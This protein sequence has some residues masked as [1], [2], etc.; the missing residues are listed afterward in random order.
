MQDDVLLVQHTG[1]AE[2]DAASLVD[3]A[4]VLCLALE[5]TCRIVAPD[6]SASRIARGEMLLIRSVSPRSGPRLVRAARE[7]DATILVVGLTP[8]LLDASL[9]RPVTRATDEPALARLVEMVRA[10]LERSPLRD[11]HAVKHLM[12]SML[13]C[14]LRGAEREAGTARDPRIA[15][16]LERMRA[17]P[18]HAFTVRALAKHAGLSRAAFARRFLAET[19]TSPQRHLT[20]LRLAR[21]ASLLVEADETL[22]AIAARVGYAN[23]FAFSRAFK[24][25]YGEA[26]QTYRRRLTSGAIRPTARTTF[27]MRMAA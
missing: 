16:V 4:L 15:R 1:V 14:V 12:A 11:A 13:L 6:G 7:G 2:L 3:R 22:A 21:A 19:G 23:E 18:H 26:P 27:A 8:T 24:R 17:D 10:E 20:A 25:V 5:G 9:L